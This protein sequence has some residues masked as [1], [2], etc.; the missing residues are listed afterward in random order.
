MPLH[1]GHDAHVAEIL[2]PA[3]EGKSHEQIAGM[4]RVG[5]VLGTLAKM[6]ALLCL[7]CF[8]WTTLPTDVTEHYCPGC[9]AF[10]DDR[11]YVFVGET[12]E[13]EAPLTET[14]ARRVFQRIMTRALEP[15][16]GRV[17]GPELES[18]IGTVLARVYLGLHLTLHPEALRS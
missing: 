7:S 12:M 17:L 9:D 11:P 18:E 1:P 4:F 6:P 5:Y 15:Y 13:L 14:E 3:L 2:G 8:R 16:R 10:L